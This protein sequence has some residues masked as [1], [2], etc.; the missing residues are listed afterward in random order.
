[1]LD[2]DREGELCPEDLHS[3]RIILY[4]HSWGASE[5]VDLARRLERERIP[6]LL[7]VQ[8]D[9]VSKFGQNDEVIPANVAQ[10]VNFYQ[11]DGFLHGTA[12]IRAAD[13][14]RTRI[15]GNFRFEYADAPYSCAAYPWYLRVFMKAHTQIE[16][17]PKIW[18]R[19]GE[20]IHSAI[21]GV[22]ER[23]N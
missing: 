21:R 2:A 20:L 8:V 1:M 14:A 3:S 22:Q 15:I 6:V 9:S 12:Q 17:D 13:P 16:C 23:G 18:T 5:V 4:G 7:T 10:A 19:V 11:T